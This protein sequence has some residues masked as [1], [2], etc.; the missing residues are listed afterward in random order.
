MSNAPIV[1]DLQNDEEP[2]MLY[3]LVLIG[4]PTTHDYGY[5]VGRIDPSLLREAEENL[6]DLLPDGYR[7]EIKEWNE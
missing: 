2:H 4:P 6:T 7:V 1:V 3:T 5:I